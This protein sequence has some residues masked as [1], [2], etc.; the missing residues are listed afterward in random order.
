MTKKA[1]SPSSAD[2]AANND[3]ARP[4]GVD[5]FEQAI[6]E[7]ETLVEQM[8]AGSLSLEESMTAYRRG[9]QLVTYCRQSLAFAQQ[10]VRVLEGELLKPF[11]PDSAQG[12]QAS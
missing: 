9:A 11:E 7:L 8:E 4:A 12:E 5:S 1:S 10:Q 3:A 6:A 2:P